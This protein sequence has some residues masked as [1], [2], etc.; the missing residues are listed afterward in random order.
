MPIAAF[1]EK[2]FDECRLPAPRLTA[3]I[4][5]AAAGSSGLLKIAESIPPNPTPLRTLAQQAGVDLAV[6]GLLSDMLRPG[7]I[8]GDLA[9][10]AR[11]QET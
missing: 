9:P 5:P 7:E 10:L 11:M 3:S 2:Y 6:D 8:L 4:P 1:P